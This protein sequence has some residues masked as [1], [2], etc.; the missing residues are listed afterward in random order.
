[1]LNVFDIILSDPAYFKQIFVK[2]VLFVAYRCPEVKTWASLWTHYNHFIYTVKGNK[3][4]K[5]PGN[6]L[7]LS[8]GDL[9]MLKKGGFSQGRFHDEDWYVI[10]LCVPDQ[11]LQGLY[12]EYRHNLPFSKIQTYPSEPILNIRVNEITKAFF[13]SLLTYLTQDQRSPEDLLE[14]KFRE[15]IFILLSNPQNEALLGYIKNISEGNKPHLS[16]IMSANYTFNLSIPEYARL[17]GRSLAA[18]KRE[19]NFTF[20]TTPGKWLMQKRLEYAKLLLDTSEKNV[21]EVAEESGFVNPSHFSRAFKDKFGT[22]PLQYRKGNPP[23]P[24]A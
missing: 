24:T 8:E 10:V 7:V 14:L 2:E 18:F 3:I 1:M 13:Q 12:K 22:P 21:N 15:L 5:A 11:Y 9:I 6:T 4:I 20:Q 17:A 23:I 19:F 16:E